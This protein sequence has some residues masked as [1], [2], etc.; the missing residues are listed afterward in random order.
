MITMNTKK[1][2]IVDTIAK[3]SENKISI[4][5]AMKLLN[6][7]RRTIEHYLQRYQVIGIE[8]IIH[9]NTGKSSV[10]KSSD[11]IKNKFQQLIKTEHYDLNLAYLQEILI[12]KENIPVKKE[13]LRRWAN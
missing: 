10:N 7:F 4:C 2:L 1:Q 3:V 13:K 5:N 8:F 6:K 11:S 12:D 9:K